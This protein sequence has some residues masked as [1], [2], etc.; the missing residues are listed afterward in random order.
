MVSVQALSKGRMKARKPLGSKKIKIRSKNKKTME[1]QQLVN[2]RLSNLP[3]SPSPF[4][5]KWI[6]D[7]TQPDSH[8]ANSTQPHSPPSHKPTLTK[9]TKRNKS[10]KRKRTKRK[11]KTHQPS[12]PLPPPLQL[13]IQHQPQPQ[14]SHAPT[15]TPPSLATTRSRHASRSVRRCRRCPSLA[16]GSG[17]RLVVGWG[18]GWRGGCGGCGWGWLLWRGFV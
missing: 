12:T 11:T 1:V 13:L 8:H 18:W 17:I 4:S 6:T 15:P 9:N 14:H 10:L 2:D 7:L 16:R 3:I 5:R